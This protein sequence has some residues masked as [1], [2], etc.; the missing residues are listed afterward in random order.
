MAVGTGGRVVYVEGIPAYL[1]GADYLQFQLNGVTVVIR[2]GLFEKPPQPAR[3]T[4][5][6]IAQSIIDRSK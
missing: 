6:E 2:L 4:V 3:P 5:Q 1:G